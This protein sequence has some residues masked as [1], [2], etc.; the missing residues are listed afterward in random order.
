MVLLDFFAYDP[1]PI[2]GQYGPRTIAAVK[3]MRSDLGVVPDG[4]VGP[5]RWGAL[6]SQL[7]FG[8]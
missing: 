6:Q 5:M 3:R 7:C 8:A 4:Q 2:D 1:G